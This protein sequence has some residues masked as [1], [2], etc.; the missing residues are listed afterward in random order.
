[1]NYTEEIRKLDKEGEKLQLKL[2]DIVRK[3]GTNAS[4]WSLYNID[5]LANI[6]HLMR[7]LRTRHIQANI[8]SKK[9]NPG[10]PEDAQV[11]RS[12]LLEAVTMRPGSDLKELHTIVQEIGDIIIDHERVILMFW[13]LLS[14]GKYFSLDEYCRVWPLYTSHG[15]GQ[16]V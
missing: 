12:L 4:R 16:G 7:D 13:A 5:D 9:N 14:Q 2:Q 1:M 11:L 3:F 8:D 6:A 15:T 10:L